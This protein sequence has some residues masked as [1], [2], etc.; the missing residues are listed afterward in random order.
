MAKILVN[1]IYVRYK[2][3]IILI[4]Y[5]RK[6]H[7]TREG[8]LFNFLKLRESQKLVLAPW[9]CRHNSRLTIRIAQMMNTQ[10]ILNFRELIAI[11]RQKEM[12]SNLFQFLIMFLDQ[13]FGSDGVNLHIVY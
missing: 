11:S 6:P 13:P 5:I 8:V 7:P 10:K 12:F 4:P 3:D 9:T 2:F 1:S